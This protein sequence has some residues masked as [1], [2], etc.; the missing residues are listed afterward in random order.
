MIEWL[1]GKKVK[2]ISDRLKDTKLYNMNPRFFY[3]LLYHP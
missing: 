2:L 3:D 1:L